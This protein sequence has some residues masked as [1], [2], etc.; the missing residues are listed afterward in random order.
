MDKR[1]SKKIYWVNFIL[2]LMIIS[3]HAYNIP[4]YQ[5]ALNGN[6]FGNIFIFA[7][8]FISCTERIAV[9]IFFAM[10]GFLFFHNYAPDKALKKIKSRVFSLLIPYFVWNSISWLYY[11]ILTHIPYVAEKMNMQMDLSLTGIIYEIGMGKYNAL[12]FVRVLFILILLA[13]I[14]YYAINGRI[15]STI[16]I[17]VLIIVEILFNFSG[18]STVYGMVFFSIGS[19]IALNYKEFVSKRICHSNILLFLFFISCAAL[20]SYIDIIQERWRLL[21]LIGLIA[22]FWIGIDN[23]IDLLPE[24]DSAHWFTK[25]SFFIYCSH[26]MILEGVEKIIL[27]IFGITVYGAA[28][29][30]IFAPL[31]TFIIIFCIAWL[32]KNKFVKIFNILT[33]GRK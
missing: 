24:K 1:L 32:M 3:Y 5:T 20:A 15:K 29:D 11:F 14:L 7:E 26:G 2:S 21:I 16:A 33:G 18:S 17:I 23:L 19:I 9:P 8:K 13:P 4:I 25:H 31:I 10:S 27:I 30:Y 6:A 28:V 12:W 22:L